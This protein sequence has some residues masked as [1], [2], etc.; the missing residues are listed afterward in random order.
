MIQNSNDSEFKCRISRTYPSMSG[1]WAANMKT[2]VLIRRRGYHQLLVWWNSKPGMEDR[3]ST[4]SKTM[5]HTAS[6]SLFSNYLGSCS[7]GSSR[8]ASWMTKAFYQPTFDNKI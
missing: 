8:T 5:K 7:V 2:A 3:N 4:Q 6:S 1:T